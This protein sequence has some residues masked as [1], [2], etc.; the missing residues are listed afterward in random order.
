M[1]AMALIRTFEPQP[2]AQTYAVAPNQTFWTLISFNL[3]SKVMA[4]FLCLHLITFIFT[5]SGR[6]SFSLAILI[7]Y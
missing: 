2:V 5:S 1:P 4:L 6:F 3:K 7:Q